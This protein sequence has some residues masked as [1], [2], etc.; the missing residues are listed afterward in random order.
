[1]FYPTGG[2]LHFSFFKRPLWERIDAFRDRLPRI[3][4][5]KQLVLY[6]LK[7][8]VHCCHGFTP[9]AASHTF[10]LQAAVVGADVYQERL[11]C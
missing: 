10:L 11:P 4:L 8:M 3:D 5:I 9:Q 6:G 2:I 1:M 7:H